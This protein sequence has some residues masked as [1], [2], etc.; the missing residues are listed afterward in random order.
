MTTPAPT[1][2][3]TLVS[4][5]ARK[6]RLEVNAGPRAEPDFIQ[7][8]GLTKFLPKIDTNLEDDTDFDS[9]GWSSQT[10]TMLGW[11]V[12]TTVKRGRGVESGVYDPGQ[13]LL[14]VAAESFG[15][16]GVVHVRWFDRDGGEEAYEGDAEVSYAPTGDSPSALSH[17]DINLTGKG[18]RRVITNPA[19]P[20]GG[21]G[22]GGV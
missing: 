7:V 5:L 11:S 19:A 3:E 6:F 9:E 14:R 21:G 22:G 18:A 16:D 17:A 20:T 2:P 13:E 15:A 4:T 12:E 8:R 1:T 10:K